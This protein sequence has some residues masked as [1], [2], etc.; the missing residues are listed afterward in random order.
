MAEQQTVHV[1]DDDPAIRSSLKWLI[2]SV[3]LT[4]RTYG[5]AQEFLDA[6]QPDE[7]GCLV[8]DV[9]MPG[10][11]GLDLQEMLKERGIQIPVIILTGYGDVPMA[12]RAMKNGAV[13]FLEKPVSD[14][15]LLDHIQQALAQDVE[16]HRRQAEQEEV[17]E[18]FARLTPR[19]KEVMDLVVEGL[20]SRE[21]AETLG[22]SFKT[23]EAH[24]SKIMKKT[25][26]K[27]VSHLIR[28]TML[29]RPDEQ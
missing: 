11:S 7:P 18:R 3:N 29:L 27:S 17:R 16:N 1:V 13:D 26:A 24:R 9:R 14:Q 23:I 2:E 15:V 25:E 12:V 4:V 21:I 5:S 28:M 19:E 10:L 22:V 20:S 8:L 6:Y